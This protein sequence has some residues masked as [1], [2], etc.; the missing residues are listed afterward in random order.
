MFCMMQ[1]PPYCSQ[2]VAKRNYNSTWILKH[3]QCMQR[4][5]V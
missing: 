4:K 2:S 5:P 1:S 3:D